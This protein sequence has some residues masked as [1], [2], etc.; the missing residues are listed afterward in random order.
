VIRVV[1]GAVIEGARVLVARRGPGMSHAGLWELPG[2]KVEAGE[3][4][5]TALARELLEEL[6][7]RVSVH[8][9]IGTSRVIAEG[10]HIEMHAYRCRITDGSP[11]AFEHA[12]LDW[13]E[14]G[15]L[16]DL[17]WAPADI[18][19]ITALTRALGTTSQC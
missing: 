17:S 13:L 11:V 14:A 15:A 3:D 19:L 9:A 8:D 18:P 1:A 2:G 7:I 12:A 6:G 4:D 10:I 5:A 16:S